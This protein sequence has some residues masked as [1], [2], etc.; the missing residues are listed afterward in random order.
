[1]TCRITAGSLGDCRRDRRHSMEQP[2]LVYTTFPDE[3]TALA[4]GEAMG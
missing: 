1:M 4:I 2:L 3:E